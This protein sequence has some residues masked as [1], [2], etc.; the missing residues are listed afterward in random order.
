MHK[1]KPYQRHYAYL[2]RK[3]SLLTFAVKI[4]LYKYAVSAGMSLNFKS[5]HYPLELLCKHGFE[6][7]RAEETTKLRESMPNM[8]LEFPENH[9]THIKY[10]QCTTMAIQ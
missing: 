8:G 7:M 1:N 2:Q 9:A 3:Q 10:L 6:R 4:T 5:L